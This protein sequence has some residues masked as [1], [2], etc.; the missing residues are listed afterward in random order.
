MDDR[1][2]SSGSRGEGG[3]IATMCW[4][5][6][7]PLQ[8]RLCPRSAATHGPGG[9]SDRGIA[10]YRAT[11][12]MGGPP[13][14]VLRRLHANSADVAAMRGGMGRSQV[15]R[16]R[17]LIPPFPG[18]NPG[19]PANDFHGLALRTPTADPRSFPLIRTKQNAKWRPKR[20]K[21]VLRPLSISGGR[22]G[23]DPKPDATSQK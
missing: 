18:S 15:V 12:Y 2:A 7:R 10:R 1:R 19:A 14:R 3:F 4:R 9:H 5:R 16:Q 21:S 6:K 23:S 8:R 13:R 20:R 22:A 11:D 17:I